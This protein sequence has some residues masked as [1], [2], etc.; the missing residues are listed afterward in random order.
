MPRVLNVKAGALS[1][2]QV[3][4]LGNV[5]GRRTSCD[6]ANLRKPLRICRM[7]AISAGSFTPASL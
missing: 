3:R 7:I 1:R 6:E 2:L 4:P 5:I